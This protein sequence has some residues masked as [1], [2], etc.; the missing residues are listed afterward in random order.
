MTDDFF[1]SLLIGWFILL[2][3][4]LFI[5]IF[6]YFRKMKETKLTKK[7]ISMSLSIFLLFFVFLLLIR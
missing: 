1:F 4:W 5:L 6:I 3:S 2:F 7:I